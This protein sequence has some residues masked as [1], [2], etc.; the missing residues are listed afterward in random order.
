MRRRLGLG[1][2]LALAGVLAFGAPAQAHNYLVG[3][4]PAAGS[5]ITALPKSIEITTND[6]LLDLAGNGNGFDIIVRD[7]T[8]RY[9]GDGCVTIS[10]ASISAAAA[11]GKPGKYTVT[12]QVVSTDSHPVSNAF[13]FV[14]APTDASQ[15]SAGSATPP[16]CHGTRTVST[17]G[18]QTAS[19]G[20]ATGTSDTTVYW[21][22]GI[23]LLLII[24]AG[25]TLLVV[26][27]KK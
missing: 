7:A 13:E 17:P 16:D 3:S 6:T 8:G 23:V 14:W 24:A 10:G 18:P 12:W 2:L 27:P 1:L 11:L 20:A 9:Y 21:V 19:S 4:T 15:E 22:G 26:R 5:T 25:V